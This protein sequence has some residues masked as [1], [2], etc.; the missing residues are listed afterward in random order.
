VTLAGFWKN[1][2]PLPE[3]GRR[4]TL[5]QIPDNS[6]RDNMGQVSHS[7]LGEVEAVYEHLGTLRR[8]DTIP[9]VTYGPMPELV[10]RMSRG[11]AGMVSGVQPLE[12]KEPAGICNRE[13]TILHVGEFREATP[14]RDEIM[15]PQMGS[16]AEEGEDTVKSSRMNVSVAEGYQEDSRITQ[17]WI[18]MN[19]EVMEVLNNLGG[20]Q[21]YVGCWRMS[22]MSSSYQP[23]ESSRS[24]A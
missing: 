15:E 1:I 8:A 13:M 24:W 3:V 5:R 23:G 9:N 10:A 22:C 14:L 7:R 2:T 4:G 16:R 21:Y 11:T 17:G 19:Q 20:C 12:L 6:H 18:R